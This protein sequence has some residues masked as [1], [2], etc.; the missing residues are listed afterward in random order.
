MV[1][2][3]TAAATPRRGPGSHAGPRAPFCLAGPG[4]PCPQTVSGPPGARPRPV[5]QD[6][7]SDQT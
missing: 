1:T 5:A 7:G 6:E 3:L 2:G 4:Q